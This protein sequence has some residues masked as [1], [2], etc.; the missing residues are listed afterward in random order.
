MRISNNYIGMEQLMTNAH[1]GVNWQH[2]RFY[3][4]ECQGRTSKLQNIK[5]MLDTYQEN[6]CVYL[7]IV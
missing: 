5:H 4:L 3:F 1:D 7:V 2:L 6:L